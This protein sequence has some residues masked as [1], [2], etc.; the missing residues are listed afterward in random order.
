MKLDQAPEV[1]LLGNFNISRDQLIRNMMDV[2]A[3]YQ[4][5]VM[6]ESTSTHDAMGEE[7]IGNTGEGQLGCKK[8]KRG[9]SGHKILGYRRCDEEQEEQI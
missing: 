9:C 2:N 1:S 4:H 5:P 6:G 3:P 8:T 7:A